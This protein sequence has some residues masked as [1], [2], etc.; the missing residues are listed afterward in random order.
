[1]LDEVVRPRGHAG[2]V[3]R[4]QRRP[5]GL[6]RRR[7][8]SRVRRLL[9]AGAQVALGAD[10]PLLFGSRLAASTVGAE[11]PG[12]GDDELAALARGSVSGSRAPGRRCARPCSTDVDAWLA[13][14]PGPDPPQRPSRAVAAPSA[15]RARQSEAPTRTGS[16]TRVTPKAS[17]TPS[18]TSRARAS[19]VGGAG[20][21]AVGQGQGVL[22]RQGR[23]AGHAVALAEAGLLDQPGGAGLDRPSA[24]RTAAGRRLGAQAGRA[25]RS[26]NAA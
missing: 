23:R 6:P 26:R 9:E 10:D 3:P 7:P 24:R 18:R 22:G 19:D 12:L 8:P 17:C 15:G 13:S 2:G 11:A 14:P 5:G 25:A 16:L 4:Q 20:A 21:A 1:M